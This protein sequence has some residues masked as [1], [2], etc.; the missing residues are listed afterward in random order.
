MTDGQKIWSGMLAGLKTQ[1]SNSTFKAWFGGS[2]V[3]DLKKSGEK[4]ILIVG[5]NNNF[6][7]EQL[8]T[9]YCLS[10][11]EAAAKNGFL[12]EVI[13]V[14]SRAE[15]SEKPLVAPLF[16]GLAPVYLSQARKNDSLNPAHN[17]ERFMVGPS[18]NLAYLAFTQ[19]A[20]NPGHMYNPLFVWGPTG[21]GKTHL[22][23]AFANE[24]LNKSID[25]K[26]LYVSAEKFTNDYI[27]SLNNRTTAVFRQKYR[28]VDVLL[29]DDIQ[30][31]AGKE[32]TQDE[33]FF[34]FNELY[35]SGRQVVLVCDRHPKDLG[36]LQDRLMNRFLGGMTVDVQLPDVELRSAILKTKCKEKG[37]V[38]S[39]EIID[40][41]ASVCTSGARELEG[42]LIQVLTLFK[43][44]SGVLSLEQVKRAI[45]RNTR[46]DKP[47]PTPGKVIEAVSRHFRISSGDLCGPRRKA[48]LVRARQVLMY[49]LRQDLRL[50][51]EGVGELTGGRDHS[52]VLYGVEKVAGQV[53]VD[54]TKRDEISRIRSI[55]Q[56]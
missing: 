26:V 10:I 15:V 28:G 4:D 44:S 14:V 42:V 20:Q 6:V 1:V 47:K 56:Q 31:F 52:T 23:Q 30:F 22:M 55:F 18:N 16:S 29:V 51:L 49:L 13:F 50:P 53:S 24:V 37:V 41:I 8:E 9:K 40:Y 7:K 11:S 27:E 46:D 33:F 45:E 2:R 36:R 32:S 19:A 34:T 39:D 54:Q 21:V 3:M 12:G 43:L 17:F 48:S 5:V 38:L 35:M 25:A